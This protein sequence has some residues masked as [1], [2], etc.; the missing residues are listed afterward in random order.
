MDWFVR[1]LFTTCCLVFAVHCASR[2]NAGTQITLAPTADSTLPAEHS[3]HN[4][5]EGANPNL[6]F[7]KED[8]VLIIAFDLSAISTARV[9]SAQ[10]LLSIDEAHDSKGWGGNGK[11][12][13]AHL[14]KA[15][16][17]EG[18]GS[19]YGLDGKAPC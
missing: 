2:A 19:R 9:V 6:I 16:W 10:L 14:L 12:V 3:R 7:K 11:V 15:T 5:N 18:D 1:A 8:D 17:S 13:D 4:D